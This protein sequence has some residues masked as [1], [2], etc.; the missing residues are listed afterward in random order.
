LEPGKEATSLPGKQMMKKPRVAR[1]VFIW[2]QPAHKRPTIAMSE[3]EQQ[4]MKALGDQQVAGLL[5]PSR[6]PKLP[7]VD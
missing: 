2:M 6:W 1:S 7:R 3:P 4:P 5:P